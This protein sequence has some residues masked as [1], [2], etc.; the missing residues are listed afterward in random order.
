MKNI[1]NH[2]VSVERPELASGDQATSELSTEQKAK[3][4]MNNRNDRAELFVPVPGTTRA[5]E[6]DST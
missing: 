2:A 6:L 3:E 5:V 1:D 4:I